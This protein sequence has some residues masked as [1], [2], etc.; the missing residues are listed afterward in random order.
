MLSHIGAQVRLTQFT[1]VSPD[2]F[3]RKH[4]LVRYFYFGGQIF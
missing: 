1:A 2:H 4:P 3:D